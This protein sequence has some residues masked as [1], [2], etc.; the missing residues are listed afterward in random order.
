MEA[1][2][3]L[4]RPVWLRVLREQGVDDDVARAVCDRIAAHYVPRQEEISVP[5]PHAAVALT[6]AAATGSPP[7]RKG[8][9][10]WPFTVSQ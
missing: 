6:G 4:Q 5:G 8:S 10:R 7:C 9:A 2:V 3:R 1:S